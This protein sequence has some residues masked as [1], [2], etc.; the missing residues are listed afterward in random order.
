MS[1]GLFFAGEEQTDRSP[2]RHL[3]PASVYQILFEIRPRNRPQRRG[4]GPMCA[5]AACHGSNNALSHDSDIA[6]VQEWLG[7]ADV[8]TTRPMTGARASP[9]DSPTFG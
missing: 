8:S 4:Y 1:K 5:F 6:K 7:H 3:D 2:D 9:K